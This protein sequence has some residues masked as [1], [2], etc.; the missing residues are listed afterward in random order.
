LKRPP[1]AGIQVEEEE[2]N[3]TSNTSS[4]SMESLGHAA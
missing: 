2:Q 3:D 4:G 1:F